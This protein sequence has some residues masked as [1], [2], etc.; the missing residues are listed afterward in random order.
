MAETLLSDI[1]E[2]MLKKVLLRAP[3]RDVVTSTMASLTYPLGKLSD[4]DS[5]TRFWQIAFADDEATETSNLVDIGKEI[6][7]KCSRLPLAIKIIGALMR[8]KK[9]KCCKMHDLVHD[10]AQATSNYYFP[11]EEYDE[12][13]EVVHLSWI[14][15]KRKYLEPQ[16][17]YLYLS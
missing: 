12:L 13:D 4:D 10:L 8:S 11:T 6:V 15:E 3:K 1:A 2:G 16:R 17:P 7:K 9:S 5:W 14:S